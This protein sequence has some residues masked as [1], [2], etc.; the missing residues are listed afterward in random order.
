MPWDETTAFK[1]EG[2]RSLRAFKVVGNLGCVVMWKPT[3]FG[4]AFEKYQHGGA[5]HIGPVTF[6]FGP[7]NPPQGEPNE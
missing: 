6:G 7:I 1:Y 4:V 2:Y 5:A 3:M